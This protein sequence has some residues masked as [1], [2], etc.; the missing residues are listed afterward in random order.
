MPEDKQNKS[1]SDKETEK[2]TPPAVEVVNE[3]L[4]ADEVKI[5]LEELDKQK[6]EYL[7][8]WQRERANFLNYKK[9]EMERISSLVAYSNEEIVAHFLPILDNFDLA[10]RQNFPTENLDGQEKEMA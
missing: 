6:A 9:E 8:G 2:K 3:E 5:K 7:A 1:K 10:T 4:S